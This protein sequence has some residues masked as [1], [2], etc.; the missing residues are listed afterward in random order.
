MSKAPILF[1]LLFRASQWGAST[2]HESRISLP[3]VLLQDEGPVEQGYLNEYDL[4]QLTRPLRR[5]KLEHPDD[6]LVYNRT[7]DKWQ[8]GVLQPLAIRGRG[9]CNVKVKMAL[10][11][12]GRPDD[13]LEDIIH[14]YG[15]EPP[16]CESCPLQGKIA[17]TTKTLLL[18]KDLT[19]RRINVTTAIRSGINEEAF[20]GLSF[21]AYHCDEARGRQQ[22][23]DY[24]LFRYV[25]AGETKFVSRLIELGANIRSRDGERWSR[26]LQALNLI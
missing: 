2:T 22:E 14:R 24:L 20:P 16:F 13:E 17:L 11:R 25:E 15:C 12:F 9:S 26:R 19:G 21:L 18:Y 8:Q 6:Y 1:L 5:H 23:L 4:V 7:A 3:K 10:K